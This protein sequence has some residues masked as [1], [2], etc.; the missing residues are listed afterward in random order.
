MKKINHWTPKYIFNRLNL[1]SFNF[2]NREA[3]WLT[4]NSIDL[5]NQIILETDK[6]IEFGAGRSTAWL[7]ERCSHLTSIETSQRWMEMVSETNAAVIESGKLDIRLVVTESQ[8]NRNMEAIADAS[9]DFALVDSDEFRDKAATHALKK[10]KPGGFIIIDNCER[11]L[12]LTSR[13]PEAIGPDGVAPSLDWKNYW[14]MTKMLPYI[15]TTSG[16]TDTIIQIKR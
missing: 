7:V 1:A 16:I 2:W 8:L 15:H 6:G 3:P 13:S 4:P 12:P 9:I 5:L 10:V 11:Y 14:E